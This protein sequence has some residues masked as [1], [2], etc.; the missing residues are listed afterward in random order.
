MNTGTPL[1]KQYL[2]IKRRHPDALLLFRI[3]DFYEA[4]DDDARVLSR[5]LGIVLTSKPMGRS[6]RVPLAG[7]PHHSLERHLATLIARGHRVAICEQLTA[8][9]VKGGPGRGLIERDVVRV[10]TP[11]TVIEPGLLQSKVNNYLA[12]YA[13]DGKRA[14]IAYADITTGEFAATE[15]EASAALA[16]LQRIAPAEILVPRKFEPKDDALPGFVTRCDDEYFSPQRARTNLLHHFGSRTLAP[17]GLANLPLAT[18]AAGALVAY[19]RE[20][21]TAAAGQLTRLTS[22]QTGNFMLLDAQTL[23]SLEIVESFGGAPSLLATL[24]ATRTAM[25]GRL[26]R[27]WLRQ[28]LLDIAEITRRH[29]HV[30]WFKENEKPRAELFAA[31]EFAH[32]LERLS[33]RVRA[34]LASAADVLALGQSLSTIPRVRSVLQQDAKRFGALLASLPTCDEVLQTIR[35]AISDELPRRNESVGIIRDGYSEELDKLREL[36]KNGR[37]FLAEMEQRERARTGIKSLR[38]G[39]NKVF[40][41]YI[42]VT[43]PNLH[44]VPASYTR[45]QTLAQ[46]ERFITL[47]LKE[48]ESLVT[49]A[50]ERIAE[51]E[52]SLFRQVCVEIGKRRD[53]IL[54]A[55]AVLAHLDAV[56]S[57]AENAARHD[58]ARP[59]LFD[60]AILRVAGGRHPVLERLVPAG[61][62]VANDCALGGDGAPEIALITGPN[63]SGKSTY[64]RQ[65]ALIVL[66]AQAGSFVPA[67]TAAVGLCDRIFT[68]IGLYDRIGSGESTFMTEMIETAQILHHASPRSLILLDELGRGTSTYDGLAVARAVVEFLHNHPALRAKTLFA[69][70][71][72]ELAE[73]SQMLPRLQNLHVEIAEE[74]GELVFLYRIS[75]GSAEHSYGVYAAK[76][77]GL[78][79]PVVRRAEELLREYEAST[80]ARTTEDTTERTHTTPAATD[81]NSQIVKALLDLDLN[82][83]SPVEAMMKLYEVRRL[84][85]EEAGEESNVRVMKTA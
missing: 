55:S 75:P 6:F 11:G 28:P 78:P 29:E 71:Y 85:E 53:E 8:E 14:G 67:R 30:G 37:G 18:A 42:E 1:R 44:L 59:T 36:L 43:R 33:G 63:M 41:H 46:A 7:V 70:H 45:K 22:Y 58:Y 68:R 54:A 12:A 40:G 34:G 19:L 79:K 16:E 4:F 35:G 47:E 57:F 62:F 74:D 21:Q 25:G 77:A 83:L 61:E 3:G 60:S 38:V 52:T 24:D 32:D 26:L 76:L 69:T 49:N 23:K 27:R 39:Y 66:M 80:R 56:A 84:A 31:L 81:R 64:L 51:L 17:Y 5:E 13:T 50:Q 65:T 20:T 2:D 82:A 72:H 73:L 48:H 15:I 9:P 10:V